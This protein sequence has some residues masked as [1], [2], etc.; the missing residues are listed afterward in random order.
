VGSIVTFKPTATDTLIIEPYYGNESNA[1]INANTGLPQ[2]ARWNAILAYY[3][4]DFND[5]EKP[6]AFSF[7]ARGEIFEDA[8]GARTC[9][10]GVNVSGGTNT[11]ATQPGATGFAPGGGI[12]NTATGLGTVQTLWEGTFTLQ[13]KPAPSLI[14]RVEF[15]YDKSN[16]SVFLDGST[17]VSSQQTL[18]FQVVYLF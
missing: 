7:R 4:H 14:T 6:H 11:C 12:F 5:Q 2:N 15:R 9:V 8:G 16:K 13:Y 1:S 17:P 18:G 10:G 3:T